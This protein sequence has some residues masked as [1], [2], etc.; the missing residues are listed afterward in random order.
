MTSVERTAYPKFKQF[1]NAKELAELYTPTSLEINFV[2]SK[3]K[4]DEGCLRLMVLLKSFQRLGYFPEQELI[5]IAVIK[6]LRSCLKLQDSVNAIPSERQRYTYKN[7]IREY[8]RVKQYDKTGQRLLAIVV[9]DAAKTKDHPADL[10]NVAIE[11]LVKERYELPAFSTLDR[12][13]RHIR[14]MVNNR[15]F[16]QVAERLSVTEQL[17]LDKLLLPTD[18]DDEEHSTLNSPTEVSHWF[19]Q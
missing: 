12:L 5:P 17:Y 2:K 11:E 14:S 13:I 6:H 3:T 10:I 19:D 9:A 1:P 7:I 15:L 16:T 8:L 4:S 18:A